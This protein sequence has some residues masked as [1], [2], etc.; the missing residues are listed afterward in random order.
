MIPVSSHVIVSASREE[1]FDFL[2]DLANRAAFADHFMKELHLT[3]PRSSGVGA[4]ARFRLDLPFSRTW[5][6]TRIAESDRPRRLVEDGTLGRQGRSAI[7]TVWALSQEAPGAVRVELTSAT[8]PGTRVDAL[9]ELYGARRWYRS[10]VEVA[11]RRLGRVFE[12]ERDRPLA[13]VGVAGYEVL[14][15]PRFGS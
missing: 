3:R 13:R 7:W 5:A 9:R 4:A 11:L 2:G 15:A 8:E 12:E 1:V 14:K 6:E 10:Q